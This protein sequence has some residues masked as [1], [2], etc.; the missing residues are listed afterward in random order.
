MQATVLAQSEDYAAALP[1]EPLTPPRRLALQAGLRATG[2]D[3][4]QLYS[5]QDG[6]W[7]LLEEVRPAGVLAVT[8]MDLSS[9]LEQRLTGDR[10][11]HSTRGVL[12]GAAPMGD[13][14]ALVA[15]MVLQPDYFESLERSGQGASFS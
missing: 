15:G 11:L 10:V 7:R 4:I 5:R 6:G 12:A 8:P 9:E 13:D 3:F 1:H 14:Y 2:L